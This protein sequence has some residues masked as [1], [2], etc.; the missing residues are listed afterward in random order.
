MLNILEKFLSFLR[1]RFP[2]PY[3]PTPHPY[4]GTSLRGRG[5]GREGGREGGEKREGGGRETGSLCEEEKVTTMPHP[6]TTMPHPEAPW[7]QVHVCADRRERP[8]QRAP[9][10]HRPVQRQ[11]PIPKLTCRVRGTVMSTL[12]PHWSRNTPQS[13]VNE[14]LVAHREDR[15]GRERPGQRAPAPHR[16]VQR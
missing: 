3:T 12:A 10:P 16:P 11:G 5:G 15:L 2:A 8:G 6:V 1:L 9:A 7:P 14:T 4:R 13:G